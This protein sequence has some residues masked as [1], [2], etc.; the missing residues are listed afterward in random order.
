MVTFEIDEAHG[1]LLIV[2]AKTLFPKPN[3]VT[4]VVGK[5]ELVNTALPETKVHAP[6]PTAGKF[7]FIVVDGEEIQSV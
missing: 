1:A 3:P 7:P 4:D 5:R 2:H 6:V